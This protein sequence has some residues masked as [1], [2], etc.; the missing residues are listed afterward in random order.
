MPCFASPTA[1]VAM[2]LKQRWDNEHLVMYVR[3]QQTVKVNVK[4]GLYKLKYATGERWYSDKELFG[5]KTAYSKANTTISFETTYSGSFVYYDSQEVTLYKVFNG[6][7]STS[8]ISEDD[9]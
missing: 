4:D 8:S 1:P 6:N 9:F 5:S 2:L 7:M 3:A